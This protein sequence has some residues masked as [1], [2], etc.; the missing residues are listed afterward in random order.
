MKENEALIFSG[1]FPTVVQTD[2]FKFVNQNK[3]N[4]FLKEFVP[5]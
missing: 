4:E 2:I 3:K 1:R 5:V